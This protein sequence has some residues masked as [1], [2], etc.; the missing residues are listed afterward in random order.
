MEKRTSCTYITEPEF[1]ENISEYVQRA[2]DTG[3]RIV[4]SL[5]DGSAFGIVHHQDAEYMQVKEDEMDMAAI[6]E[7]R[8]N[9]DFEHTI[10]LEELIKKFEEDDAKADERWRQKKD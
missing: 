3:E 1:R 6:E 10:T 4:V 9:G 5:P 8:R 2:A 7:A